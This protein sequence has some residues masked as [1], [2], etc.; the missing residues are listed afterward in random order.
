MSRA[1]RRTITNS[2]DIAIQARNADGI[3][4]FANGPGGSLTIQNSGSIT[5]KGVFEFG[6]YTGTFEPSSPL[7]IEISGDVHGTTASIYGYSATSTKIVN[8]GSIGAASNRAINTIGTSTTSTI[9]D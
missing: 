2:G 8:S 1:K 9:R 7:M 5:A 4:S 3:F 6:I